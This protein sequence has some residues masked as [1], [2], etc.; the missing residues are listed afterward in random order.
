MARKRVA[1]AFKEIDEIKEDIK[2]LKFQMYTNAI[3]LLVSVGTLAY[4]IS[5]VR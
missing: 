5:Q 3:A 4:I 1:D 2:K